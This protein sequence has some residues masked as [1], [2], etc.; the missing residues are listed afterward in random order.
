MIEEQTPWVIEPGSIRSDSATDMMGK[1]DQYGKLAT[2]YTIGS[3][4]NDDIK[5]F[6]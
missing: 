1:T 5:E 6:I 4:E 2:K 3:D